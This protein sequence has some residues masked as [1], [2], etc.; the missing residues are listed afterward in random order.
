MD[1]EIKHM[2]RNI[3]GEGV[4]RTWMIGREYSWKTLWEVMLRGLGVYQVTSHAHLRTDYL[5]GSTQDCV[6]SLYSLVPRW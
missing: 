6:L 1:I 3:V 2:M 5:S 4:L